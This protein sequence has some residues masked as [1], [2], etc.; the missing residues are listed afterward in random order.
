MSRQLLILRHGKSD[1]GVEIK[2]FDRPLKKRGKRA[3]QRM[4][5]WLQQQNLVSDY[6]LSSPAE[7]ARNTA[8]KL[9]KAMG[10]TAQRVHYDSRLYA[11]NQEHLKN[12]L[13]SCP[14]DAQRVLLIGHNPELESLLAF[15]SKD[16]LPTPD[17]G[18]LLP[19]ATLAIF[20]MPDDWHALNRGCGELLN[21]I[22]PAD[23]P[24]SFPFN[25]LLGI[26]QRE[27]PAYYYTQSAAIP[28]RIHN[29]ELQI[30]LISSSG[31]NHWGIPKGIIEP[32][33][34]AAKSAAIEAWEEAGIEGIISEQMLDYY[35][36]EKWGSTCT[37]QVYPMLVTQMLNN[38]EWQESHRR[39]QWLP[40]QKATFLIKQKAL[41]AMFTSLATRL[42]SKTD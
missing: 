1:W 6:I 34:S 2:D 41:Q 20:S 19:T 27:R 17:D 5:S 22:R 39:R 25:G 38:E 24:E 32:G 37:V 11:A 26:E 40:L 42:A 28:Y 12:A 29:N 8:E 14:P 23:L 33:Q 15:L 31:D 18:K 3:A 4:G 35:L 36:H 9:A 30:L 13:A 16:K 10:L 7:R 21:I